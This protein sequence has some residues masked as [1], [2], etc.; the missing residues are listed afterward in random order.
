MEYLNDNRYLLFISIFFNFSND[1]FFRFVQPYIF[2]YTSV[3]CIIKNWT[4]KRNKGIQLFSSFFSN[5]FL[6]FS[7]FFKKATFKNKIKYITIIA[8]STII[9]QQ[10]PNP[11]NSYRTRKIAIECSSYQSIGI[12]S[13]WN[14][15]VLFW[16]QFLPLILNSFFSSVEFLW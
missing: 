2:R 14:C 5:S 13:L 11:K 1:L 16:S 6:V 9:L 3:T 7:Y 10:N 12:W 4:R 15:A 8:W